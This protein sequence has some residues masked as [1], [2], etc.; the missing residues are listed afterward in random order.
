MRKIAAA[1]ATAGETILLC[2]NEEWNRT[3][4]IVPA[5]AAEGGTILYFPDLG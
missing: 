2:G 3:R 1:T 4:K 5:T